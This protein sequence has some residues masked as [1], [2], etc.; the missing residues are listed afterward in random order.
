MMLTPFLTLDSDERAE[1]EVDDDTCI[2]RGREWSQVVTDLNTGQHWMLAGAN[3]GASSRCFCAAIIICEV[4]DEMKE[5]ITPLAS[6][7]HPDWEEL[8]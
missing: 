5:A 6:R 7:T 8:T 3:C 4:S 1:M 2:P